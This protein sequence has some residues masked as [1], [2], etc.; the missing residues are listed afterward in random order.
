M[1]QGA[2][3]LRTIETVHLVQLQCM[4][5][6]LLK[7]NIFNNSK[8]QSTNKGTVQNIYSKTLYQISIIWCRMT[9]TQ[10]G[11]QLQWA[12]TEDL[13]LVQY[14]CLRIMLLSTHLIYILPSYTFPG[15]VSINICASSS[16]SQYCYTQYCIQ[17]NNP[18]L[19]CN[20][21]YTGLCLK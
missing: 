7:R 18:Q 11:L 16:S 1:Q 8:E 17:F 6:L 5:V 3:T 14:T 9:Q 20:P 13:I 21:I 19:N 15:A 4:N 12:V 2:L 10:T